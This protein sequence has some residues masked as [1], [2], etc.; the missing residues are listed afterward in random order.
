MSNSRS[1]IV[2]RL[3]SADNMS[4]GSR[5]FLAF[6]LTQVI[7]GL[8]F[9]A[10][11]SEW[12]SW[13]TN[14]TKKN[15]VDGA[16]IQSISS[17][18]QL[19][20]TNIYYNGTGYRISS[21]TSA[22]TAANVAAITTYYNWGGDNAQY[23]KVIHTRFSCFCLASAN[24]S[25]GRRLL[26][27]VFRFFHHRAH[28]RQHPWSEFVAHLFLCHSKLLHQIMWNV[29]FALPFRRACSRD[30]G[31]EHHCTSWFSWSHSRVF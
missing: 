18:S 5:N 31:I 16:G 3:P 7:V 14:Y 27:A 21:R 15:A 12:Y 23:S 13:T 8:M 26:Q 1:R 20:Y 22:Q 10:I 29:I 25:P 2:E 30:P 9:A 19:N 24:S 4:F 17:T 28:H 6:F 11:F